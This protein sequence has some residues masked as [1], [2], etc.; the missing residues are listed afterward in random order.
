MKPAAKTPKTVDAYIAGF[1]AEVR[2]RLEKVRATIHKAAPG[3]GEMISYRIPAVTLEGKY[4]VYFAAFKQHIGMYP[5]PRGSE[6]FKQELE[7][8]AGGT[9]TV[10]FPF[11]RPLPLGLI[12]RIVKFRIEENREQAKSK[13]KKKAK[14]KAKKKK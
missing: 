2:E 10:R 9:G 5:A 13:A 12:A 8:Y 11:D 1:P 6:K 4:V 3:A 14:S 7:G